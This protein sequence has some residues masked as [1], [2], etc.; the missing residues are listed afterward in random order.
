MDICLF[1]DLNKTFRSSA[2]DSICLMSFLG[3]NDGPSLSFI[4]K[5]YGRF[6]PQ[7]FYLIFF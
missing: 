1:F 2:P 7:S 4:L 3:E 6:A 5:F